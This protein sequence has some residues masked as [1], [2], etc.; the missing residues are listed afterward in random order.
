MLHVTKSILY[1]KGLIKNPTKAKLNNNFDE[2]VQLGNIEKEK[3]PRGKNG[4]NNG[5]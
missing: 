4:S 5:V 2:L 3:T 1:R